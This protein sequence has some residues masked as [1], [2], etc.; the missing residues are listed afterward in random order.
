M[1]VNREYKDSV[2]SLLFGDPAILREL[3][4]AMEGVSLPPNEPI[5]I[6]TLEGA[7]YMDRLNDLSF[8]VGKKLVV[9]IEQ[10]S[11]INLNMPLRILMYIARV[12][13]KIVATKNIYA[14]GLI[15]IPLPELIVLY[16]GPDTDWDTQE[17]KLSDAFEDA[18]ALGVD[19]TMPSPLELSATMFNINQGHNKAMLQKSETLNGYSAFVSK[20]REFEKGN[21]D[22]ATAIKKA[23]EYC[24]DRNILKEFL[25]SH[26]SEVINMLF[27]E[28]NQEEAL[29]YRF[30]EGIGIGMEKGI[31]IGIEKGRNEGR[32]ESAKKFLAMGLEPEKIARGTGLSLETIKGIA[33]TLGTQA[34]RQ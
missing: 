24:I 1:D 31:G 19:M 8:T 14:K 4:N 15:K 9:L 30:N 10:Q 26:S 27:A 33:S 6:N 5:T 7:L 11:T 34:P 28:W 23:V 12:Y 16:N 25:E 3:Y 32:V 29:E 22:L 18:S 21:N 17:L 20:V 13:E 2:F